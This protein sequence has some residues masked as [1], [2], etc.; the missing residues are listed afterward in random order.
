MAEQL[1]PEEWADIMNEAFEYLTGPVYRYEG[2]VARLMGD[3]IL[4]FFGAPTSHED[5]P[6]RA[7]L[8]GLDIVSSIAPFREQIKKE[9]GFDFDVRVGINTG[10]VVVGDVGSA[11]AFEYTAMGDAVN[12]AARME[13]TALPG[14]VQVAETTY[15]LI[16]PLFEFESLGGVEVKG[17]NEPVPSYRALQPKAEPGRVRGIEGLDSPLVGRDAEL[18]TLSEILEGAAQGR[19]HIVSLIGEAGLGKSRLMAEVRAE[20]EAQGRFWAEGRGVAYDMNR[21]YGVFY[22]LAHRLCG[23]NESD[24]PQQAHDKIQLAF[25]EFPEEER[26]QAVQATEMLLA[27]QGLDRP[28]LQGDAFKRELFAAMRGI[29]RIAGQKCTVLVM[30]DIHWADPESM[31]LLLHLVD[32]VEEVPLVLICAFRPDRQANS[33]K[34]RQQVE[35]D[36]PHLYTEINLQP[37]KGEDTQTLVNNLLAISDLPDQARQLI[38]EKTEGNP[39]FIEEVVRT[40]IDSGVVERDETGE[41]WRATTAIE[42]IAIPDNLQALLVSRIDKLDPEARRTL[43]VASVI[44]RSFYYQV[45]KRVSDE[46]VA[47]DRQLSTLQRVDLIREAARVPD[48]EFMFRHELTRQAAYDSILRRSRPEFHRQ[49]GE[50]MEQVFA[51]RLD[52]ES[53]RLAYHF[54]E[55]K[56][57]DRALWY[58][59][60]AATN[61]A[62]LYANNEA[63]R[64]YGRALEIADRLGLESKVIADLATKRGRT[65]ELAN[66]LDEALE[67]YQELEKRGRESGDKVL[68]LAGISPLG[69]MLALLNKLSDPVKSRELSQYGLELAEEMDDPRGKAKTLWNLMLACYFGAG[70][71]Q[72][73]IDYGE[74]SIAIAREHGLKEELAYALNDINRPYFEV[75]EFDGAAAAISEAASLWRELNNLPMLADNIDAMADQYVFMG[76]MKEGRELLTE[77][78]ALCR[79]IGNIWAESVAVLT[80]AFLDLE[81]GEFGSALA[82]TKAGE[83]LAIQSGFMGI[84][85][86]TGAVRSVILGALGADDEAVEASSSALHHST[87]TP[88]AAAAAMGARLQV[89]HYSGKNEISKAE[90]TAMIDDTESLVTNRY[91]QILF[92]VL[93]DVI[94]SRGMHEETVRLADQ[95]LA[96]KAAKSIRF[97]APHLHLL[98]G[99]ALDA[100][101]RDAEAKNALLEGIAVA[102][103]FGLTRNLW[104]LY[105]ELAKH[106]ERA[107]E[108]DAAKK[109]RVQAREIVQHIGRGTGSE[110]LTASF[111]AK[112]DVKAILEA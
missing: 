15:R 62:H 102:E 109:H 56:D 106:E 19:G 16:A 98:K 59:V 111:F 84:F 90:L 37:L 53:H 101:G 89:D 52:E 57:D 45:L 22:H 18:A 7:V 58:S 49:V 108:I 78:L 71:N 47:L 107:G 33:W 4:A 63:V 74:R 23:L 67:S 60:S 20:W 21:P 105:A 94:A 29:W 34:F 86:F 36:Y 61:A 27:V 12:V 55:A 35:A 110:S 76:L 66:R 87:D 65:L 80:G 38:L 95:T 82:G 96:L 40:L 97:G 3:A 41:H 77:T 26:P 10:P 32:L 14:T 93:G 81:E 83:A 92:N 8:A 50:A 5:D 28:D 85:V 24:T 43:Q 48:V 51:G 75:G 79:S 31:E 2:T 68:E 42:K 100:M 46:S 25:A 70:T 69:T 6:Q 9:Y 17:K 104:E 11:Q 64:H 30:D 91:L 39:F 99:K 1:D 112:P 88:W 72:E 44:G 73:A 103:E 13:Q 54:S